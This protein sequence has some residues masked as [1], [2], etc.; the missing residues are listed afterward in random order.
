MIQRIKMS[1]QKSSWKNNKKSGGN[2]GQFKGETPELNGQVFLLGG[3]N[4]EGIY[5]RV[6]RT[7]ASFIGRKY[8]REM[9]VMVLEGR[10]V[11]PEEPKV[12]RESDIEIVIDEDMT[13]K[14]I[15]KERREQLAEEKE[16]YR[17]NYKQYLSER[18]AYKAS[19]TKAYHIIKGQCTQAMKNK[20][21]KQDDYKTWEDND[22]V[23]GL[24]EGIK[25]IVYNGGVKQ[26]YYWQMQ[27]AVRKVMVMSQGKNETLAKY[28]ERFVSQ[29]RATE[30]LT[31]TMYLTKIKDPTKT[32][33]KE[34]SEKFLACVFLNGTDH[35]RFRDIIVDLNNAQVAG[36]DQ[37]P[38]TVEDM[39]Q[40][41]SNRW[42]VK[43]SLS[44]GGYSIS[45]AQS[46]VSSDKSHI[47]CFKCKKY[48]HYKNKCPLLKKN[49]SENSDSSVSSDE[50]SGYHSAVP[51]NR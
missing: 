36:E 3:N 13:P 34:E 5:V 44:Q 15:N 33:I 30:S 43:S 8:G 14:E 29:V 1:S 18:S 10:E 48:G 47:Q 38:K 23:V 31:G 27:E 41:V 45:F 32:Q 16:K 40:F 26:Y 25:E 4:T 49:K 51:W 20:L 35:S 42:D 9:Y 2:G 24:L 21:A 46:D 39:F 19:K 12:P 37:Y 28:H 50:I 11:P 7:I 22:D 6:R 17:M